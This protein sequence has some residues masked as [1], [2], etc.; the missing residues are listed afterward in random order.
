MAAFFA[1]RR[2]HTRMGVD[3]ERKRESRRRGL[4]VVDFFRFRSSLSLGILFHVHALRRR[5]TNPTKPLYARNLQPRATTGGPLQR[6]WCFFQDD[7]AED[8]SM[9]QAA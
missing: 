4:P 9:P 2:A 7:E 1:S 8:V 5:L 3:R 6:F